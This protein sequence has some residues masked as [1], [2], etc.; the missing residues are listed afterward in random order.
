MNM[1]GFD[2]ESSLGLTRGTYRGKAV[3]GRLGTGEISPAQEFLASSARSRNLDLLS[4]GSIVLKRELC[5]LRGCA[6]S[7]FKDCKCQ[8]GFPVCTPWVFVRD[9]L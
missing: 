6:N 7:L 1:P 4:L 9:D 3:F 2:A 5:C 8:N